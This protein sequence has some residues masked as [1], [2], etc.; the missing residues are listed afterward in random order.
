MSTAPLIVIEQKLALVGGKIVMLL[1]LR[2]QDGSYILTV[3]ISRTAKS[4]L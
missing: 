3:V 4:Y 2:I 1:P